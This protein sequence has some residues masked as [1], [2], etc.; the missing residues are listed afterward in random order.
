MAV[1]LMHAVMHGTQNTETSYISMNS[2]IVNVVHVF[3]LAI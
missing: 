3:F 2:S 1:I